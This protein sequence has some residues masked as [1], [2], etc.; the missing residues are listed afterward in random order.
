MSHVNLYIGMGVMETLKA[1]RSSY[2]SHEFDF[3]PAVFLDEV[4]G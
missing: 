3:L 2:D 4:N 1:F